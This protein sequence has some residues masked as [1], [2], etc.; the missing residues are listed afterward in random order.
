M[1]DFISD[2]YI[3]SE[4]DEVIEEPVCVEDITSQY[5]VDIRKIDIFLSCI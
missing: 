5:C 4:L 3:L 2:E 1:S